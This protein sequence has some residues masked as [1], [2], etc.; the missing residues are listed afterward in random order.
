[1]LG[2]G[3]HEG[4][5]EWHEKVSENVIPLCEDVAFALSRNIVSR[6][7][8]FRNGWRILSTIL[9]ASS[10]PSVSHSGPLCC[11]ASQGRHRDRM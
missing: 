3:T 6:I 10:S 2:S 11:T 4:E 7:I 9:H 5:K 8:G 1:M